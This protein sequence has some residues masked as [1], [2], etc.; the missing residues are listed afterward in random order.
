MPDSLC[1]KIS[2]NVQASYGNTFF[3]RVVVFETIHQI[4]N[5]SQINPPTIILNCFNQQQQQQKKAQ[6]SSRKKI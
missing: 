4:N 5:A 3:L 1:V 2:E 6:L